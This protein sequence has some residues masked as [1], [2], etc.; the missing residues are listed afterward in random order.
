MSAE[1]DNILAELAEIK[2]SLKVSK[3]PLADE[4][5]VELDIPVHTIGDNAFNLALAR[6]VRRQGAELVKCKTRD[7][8]RDLLSYIGDTIDGLVGIEKAADSISN[9]TKRR[10]S[11]VDRQLNTPYQAAFNTLSALFS[12]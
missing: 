6:W 3:S 1:L 10:T 12:D 11:R 8:R 5:D 9:G 7:Q 4:G 2:E